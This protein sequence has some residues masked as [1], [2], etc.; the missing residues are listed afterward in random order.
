MIDRFL[1]FRADKADEDR[2]KKGVEITGDEGRAKF[3][4]GAEATDAR[5]QQETDKLNI[6]QRVLSEK[7]Q[8]NEVITPEGTIDMRSNTAENQQREAADQQALKE[9]KDAAANQ[10]RN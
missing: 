8:Y 1:G 3:N 7:P 10:A 6:D 2:K 4:S 9:A 5:N